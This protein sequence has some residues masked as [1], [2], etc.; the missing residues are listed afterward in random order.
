M[1]RE[2][3]MREA[4]VQVADPRWLPPSQ[5]AYDAKVATA[6]ADA[7]RARVVEWLRAHPDVI[8]DV[9]QVARAIERGEHW[10]ERAD[11]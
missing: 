5:Q 6:G 8:R 1:T 10:Q 7:E 9:R 11:G 4:A 2:Q 3:A